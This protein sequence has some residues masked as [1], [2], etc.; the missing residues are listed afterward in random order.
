MEHLKN[1]IIRQ[2]C[3]SMP[4]ITS[5]RRHF[6]TNPELSFKEHLTA[7]Y[8]SR[9]LDAMKIK[10][11]SG[12]AGTGIVAFIDGAGENGSIVALRADMDALPVTEENNVPYRS[13]NKGVMHA[14]GHD[15]NMAVLLGAAKILNNIRDTIAGKA[16]LIFQPGEEL[17]PGGASLII[18]SGVLENPKPDVVLG[19]HVL[20]ELETGCV[21]FRGGRYMAS[22]DEINITIKGKGGHA[23]LPAQTTDQIYIA[24]QLIVT[25]KDRIKAEQQKRNTDTVL[26]I[27][28]I[29]GPG[30]NNVIP[31]T[32]TINGTFRTFSE[33]WRK[34]SMELMKA[35]SSDIAGK[36]GVEINLNVKPGYPVLVNNEILTERAI[37]LST[38]LLGKDKV[39]MLDIRMGSDDFAF[40]T[41]L[42]PSLYY[43]I[44]IRKPED[45]VRALHTSGFDIDENALFTGVSSLTWLTVNFMKNRSTGKQ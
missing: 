36:Y 35:I 42:F 20:P 41:Q 10:H 7:E 4:E 1:L 37:A 23:A 22:S 45:P 6:H 14:C 26:G 21:G 19:L 39:K 5:H 25:L 24:S 38:D 30:A 2:A 15:A 32:V 11:I 8:I 31:A 28:K 3:N 17:S 27:G 34:D 9:Q 33:S 40:Y 43:R 18:K 13:I 44:G 29:D 16:I 12:V